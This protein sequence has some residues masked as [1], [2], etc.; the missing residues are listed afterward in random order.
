MQLQCNYCSCELLKPF[1]VESAGQGV[2]F[3]KSWPEAFIC[4]FSDPSVLSAPP[5]SPA[6]SPHPD[7]PRPDGGVGAARIYRHHRQ[8]RGHEVHEGGR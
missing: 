1:V 3:V 6:F 5:C 4:C 8:R 7:M 2:Y